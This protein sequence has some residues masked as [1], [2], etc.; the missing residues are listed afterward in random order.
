[1]WNSLRRRTRCL[2]LEQRAQSLVRRRLGNCFLDGGSGPLDPSVLAITGMHLSTISKCWSIPSA[3]SLLQ[4]MP[5]KF[6][7]DLSYSIACLEFNDGN[8][9]QDQD[10]TKTHHQPSA[11]TTTNSDFTHN[12]KLWVRK[13]GL[14]V[15]G[16]QE[17][18]QLSGAY[19]TRQAS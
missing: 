17:S 1:M 8:P 9:Y 13:S 6:K 18:I 14:L 19:A 12:H 4:S 2:L 11:L 15:R 16:Y 7:S 10:M 5:C 3:L